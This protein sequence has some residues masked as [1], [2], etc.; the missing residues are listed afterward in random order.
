M[1]DVIQIAA[2]IVTVA[3]GVAGGAFIAWRFVR[4]IR[5]VLLP[6]DKDT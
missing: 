5:V 6:E 3:G 4:R 1:A 2:N